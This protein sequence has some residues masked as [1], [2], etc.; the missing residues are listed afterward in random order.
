VSIR[1]FPWR[2]PL[3][4]ETPSQDV[5]RV[6]FVDRCCLKVNSEHTEDSYLGYVLYLLFINDVS[7]TCIGQAKLKL[8]ADDIKLHH[9]FQS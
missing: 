3:F 4:S 1:M 9:I 5:A 8:F 7:F 6:V 2:V